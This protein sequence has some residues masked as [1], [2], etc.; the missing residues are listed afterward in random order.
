MP[1]P[2]VTRRIHRLERYLSRARVI[3]WIGVAVVVAVLLALAV[4]GH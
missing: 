4:S 1:E 2:P 3:L